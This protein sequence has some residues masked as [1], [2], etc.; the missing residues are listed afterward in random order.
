MPSLELP[1]DATVAML[2][3]INLPL[4][5]ATEDLLLVV[6]VRECPGA[7]VLFGHALQS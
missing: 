6:E 4:G 2:S 7:S 1:G 3:L 5:S